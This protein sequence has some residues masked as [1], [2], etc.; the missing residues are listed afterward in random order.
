M[1]PHSVDNENQQ[2]QDHELI[3]SGPKHPGLPGAT[4]LSILDE[5]SKQQPDKTALLSPSQNVSLTYSELRESSFNLA[6][7]LLAHGVRPKDR[8]VV[9]AGNTVEYVQLLLAVGSIGAVFAI[10]N[11]TFAIEEVVSAVE[12]LGRF[13]CAP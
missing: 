3:H 10:I 13:S 2:S 11:P 4:I 12:F 1:S 6:R 8:V 9:L 5:Q 7:N